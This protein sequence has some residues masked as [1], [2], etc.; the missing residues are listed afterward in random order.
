[1]SMGA[2]ETNM[3][4]RE[5]AFVRRDSEPLTS[6]VQKRQQEEAA[7]EQHQTAEGEQPFPPV[8]EGTE[9]VTSSVTDPKTGSRDAVDTAERQLTVAKV[10]RAETPIRNP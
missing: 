5:T 1:M 9:P 10:S 6:A 8:L 2:W 3:L 4:E 7:A